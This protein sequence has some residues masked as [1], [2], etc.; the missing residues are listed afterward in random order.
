MVSYGRGI[1]GRVVVRGIR[2]SKIREG[3]DV[4]GR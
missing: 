1:K 2:G 3:G 4:D